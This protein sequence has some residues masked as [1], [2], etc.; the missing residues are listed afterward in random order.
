ME[1]KQSGEVR[2]DLTPSQWA[3][4]LGIP[5]QIIQEVK[6]FSSAGWALDSNNQPRN[7]NAWEMKALALQAY[8]S[9]LSVLGKQLFFL[10]N[11]IYVGKSGKVSI[12]RRDTG[13][14]FVRAT[15]RPASKQERENYGIVNNDP[16]EPMLYEHLWFAEVYAKVEGKV[17]KV[18]DSFGHACIS[19]IHL[20]YKEKDPIRLCADMASTRAISRAL[21]LVYDFFGLESWEE[22]VLGQEIPATAVV[23]E[24]RSVKD[25][26]LDKIGTVPAE[27]VSPPP[28]AEPP[29]PVE[30]IQ[31]KLIDEI[32]GLFSEHGKKFSQA[33]R[34]FYSN[35]KNVEDYGEAELLTIRDRLFKKIG[36]DIP[37]A[38]EPEEAEGS[39]GQE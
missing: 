27:Q 8:K 32:M 38:G 31:S 2:D 10:G 23:V 20:K 33:E 30:T 34:T 4:K 13:I 17:E 15:V 12:A 5:E 37:K 26:I 16:A 29:V 14:P 24:T 35:R 39:E 21:S 1:T 22:V 11:G 7:L 36:I 18:S 9:G 19:N 3:V 28:P 25:K 6:T